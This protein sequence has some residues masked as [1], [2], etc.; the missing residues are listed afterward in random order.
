M[1]RCPVF[2]VCGVDQ[3]CVSVKVRK[4][5]GAGMR[6]VVSGSR[7]CWLEWREVVFDEVVV[8]YESFILGL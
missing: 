4:E 7:S 1:P 5:D 2:Y 3:I 8:W 6:R